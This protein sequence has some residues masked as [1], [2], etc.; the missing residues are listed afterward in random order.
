[1]PGTWQSLGTDGFGIADTRAAARRFFQVDAA[2]IVVGVLQTLARQ[3]E[4]KS[5]TVA[6]AFT[7]FKLDD[8]T[9]VAGVPQEG[10]DA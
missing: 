7:R 3:G 1:M 2:S 4:I 6:E 9:A 5:A 10:G 8:P